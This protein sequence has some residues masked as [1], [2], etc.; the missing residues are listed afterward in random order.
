MN[1]VR[2]YIDRIESELGSF[3]NDLEPLSNPV[4]DQMFAF[5]D[6]DVI[7]DDFETYQKRG[8]EVIDRVRAGA[9][10]PMI[11]LTASLLEAAETKPGNQVPINQTLYDWY[12]DKGMPHSPPDAIDFQPNGIRVYVTNFQLGHVLRTLTTET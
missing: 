5:V 12:V 4:V 11:Q 7:I 10:R 9:R 3:A 8:A 1:M 2:E 6:R